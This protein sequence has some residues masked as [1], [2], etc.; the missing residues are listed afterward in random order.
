[1]ALQQHATGPETIEQLAAAKSLHADNEMLSSVFLR[2]RGGLC[3]RAFRILGSREDAEDVVQ[4]G[5]VRAIEK[6]STF[7]GRSQFSTWLTRIVINE[8][9]MRLRKRRRAPQIAALDADEPVDILDL[10]PAT[11]PSPEAVAARRE[12]ESQVASEISNLPRRSRQTFQLCAIEEWTLSEVAE[13]LGV[14]TSTAKS[15][16]H[17]A[18][19]RIARRMRSFRAAG[20]ASSRLQRTVARAA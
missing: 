5:M 3:A 16:Y 4:E 8:A 14:N 7:Q 1:M 9:L 6:L 11:G 17:R 15:Q 10:L 20:R 19:K 2:Y 18:R 12:I 13:E